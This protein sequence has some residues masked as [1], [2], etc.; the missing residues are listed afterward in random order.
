MVRDRIDAPLA[1]DLVD[2]GLG[3][4]PVGQEADPA[5]RIGAHTGV[6]VELLHQLMRDVVALQVGAQH[7]DEVLAA[8][9]LIAHRIH[10]GPDAI[11]RDAVLPGGELAGLIKPGLQGVSRDRTEPAVADVVLAGPHHLDRPARFLRHQH[12]VDDEIDVAVAAPAE[13]AAH[14]HVVQL[15]L[16]LRDAEDLGRRFGRGGLAL[17]AGPDFDRIARGRHRRDGVQRLHL[18]VIGIVAAVLGLH[19]GGSLRH[20]RRADRRSGSIRW[21]P[22]AGFLASAANR[23][24]P[25]SLSKPQAVPVRLQVTDCGQ[26]LM[27]VERRPWRFGENA[28]AVGQAHDAHDAGDRLGLAL[29]DLVG[30]RAFDRR[31]QHRAVEHVRHLQVDGVTGACR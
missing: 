2:E 3:G 22:R 12:R 19:G 5:Q 20:L 15:H 25:L 14:Q 27:R 13:A 11:D 26:R 30:H 28:D 7:R 6:A 8:G 23:S 10:V 9:R 1:R 4:K 29:V 17:R 16:V 21:T 24:R 31:A 18:R